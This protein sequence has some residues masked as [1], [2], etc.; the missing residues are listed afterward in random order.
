MKKITIFLEKIASW[1][2]RLITPNVA[3]TFLASNV[4]LSRKSHL[5]PGTDKAELTRKSS[6]LSSSQELDLMPPISVRV[7]R[8]QHLNLFIET[9]K[10]SWLPQRMGTLSN[11]STISWF[12]LCLEVV[13]RSQI[14]VSRC[15]WRSSSRHKSMTPSQSQK[16]GDRVGPKIHLS[17]WI[18]SQSKTPC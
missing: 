16:I 14:T 10:S 2:V 6:T 11:A 17:C 4:S 9:L 12:N 5:H 13:L 8:D 1:F 3:L 15:T 7:R 18:R